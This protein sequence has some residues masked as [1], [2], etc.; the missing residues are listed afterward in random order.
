MNDLI[1]EPKDW[2]P[3]TGVSPDYWIVRIRL[4]SGQKPKL[5][6][7]ECVGKHSWSELGTEI[8]DPVHCLKLFSRIMVPRRIISETRETWT[9]RNIEVVLD[10]VRHLGKFIEIEGPEAEVRKLA[11]QLGFR[12]EQAAPGYG[13]L[14]FWLE[15]D[16][17]LT[18]D[19]KE[20][21]AALDEFLALPPA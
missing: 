6:L 10:N 3:G 4:V 11:S 16:G 8:D 19:F 5:E 20:M 17:K 13:T 15:R 12:A 9:R 18:F 7:K 21:E 14:L 2:I 1:F